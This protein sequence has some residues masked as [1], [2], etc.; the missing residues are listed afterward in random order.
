IRNGSTNFTAVN[1]SSGGGNSFFFYNFTGRSDG[2]Y[3]FFGW[4][5]DSAG[6]VVQSANRTI[7]VDTAGPVIS[8]DTTSFA[9]GT[10]NKFVTINVTS[11]DSSNDHN[12][13]SAF[14]DFNR[15]LA[16]YWRF[17]MEGA[18]ATETNA[19]DFTGYNNHG[20]LT[21]FGCTTL[22][23]NL[24]GGTG[25]TGS[26]WTSGGKRGRALAF[27][28]ENDF[29][30]VSDSSSLKLSG[31]VT[32]EGWVYPR[33]AP[34]AG[35]NYAVVGKAAAGTV[36]YLLFVNATHV[37]FNTTAQ[38]VSAAVRA[39]TV[40]A[41]SYVGASFDGL[42]VR[43]YVNGLLNATVAQTAA[44]SSTSGHL[45]VGRLGGNSAMF[46]NGSVDEV[47]VWN[48]TLSAVE[49]NASYQGGVY[50]LITNITG[51]QYPDGNYTYAAYTVDASG[52][53][54]RTEERVAVL[55][56]TLPTINSVRL[57]Y[58]NMS[59]CAY[60][61]PGS[62]TTSAATVYFNSLLGSSGVEE[63]GGQQVNIE[64]VYTDLYRNSMSGNLTFSDLPANHT[65]AD[66]TIIAYTIETGSGNATTAIYANDTA[67]NT[68]IAN[69]TFR[70]DMNDTV[71]TD[72]SSSSF[73]WVTSNVTINLTVSD[74]GATSASGANR[75][76]YCTYT[77]G[78]T[79]CIPTVEVKNNVDF[80]LP[81]NCSGGSSCTI[82]V[83]Y[84]SI[85]NV[86]NNESGG[87]NGGAIRESNT[88]NIGTG[89][90]DVQDSLVNNSAIL[91][92][93]FVR[94]SNVTNSTLNNCRVTGAVI[95]RS[96]LS[97]DLSHRFN[98][99]ISD[100]WVID[101]NITS[102]IIEKNSLVDP[103][104]VID[105]VITNSSVLNST[106]SFS[107]VENTV[108]CGN[109]TLWT[110]AVLN[111]TLVD[112]R[113][114]FNKSVYFGPM[115]LSSIC[116]GVSSSPVGSLVAEPVVVNNSA[117]MAFRYTG[118]STGYIVTIS[119]AE[120]QKLDNSSRTSI[121][122]NDNAVSP[123][124]V[125]NDAVYTANY[126]MSSLNNQSDGNKSIVAH[127]FD[128]L[129]NNWT[130]R[131]NVTLDNAVPYVAMVANSN[132]M[133][134][135]S[136]FVNLNITFSD[137][138]GV[139]DCRFANENRVFGGFEACTNS[140]VWALTGGNGVKTVVVQ[141][142]DTA[143]NVN[144]TN[145]TITLVTGGEGATIIISPQ[146]N[147][148][149]RGSKLVIV[150]A[151]DTVGWVTFNITNATNSSHTW[152]LAGTNNT[153]TNDT[154][155]DDGFSNT[156]TTT[157]AAFASESKFNLTVISYDANGNQLSN[158]TK[159]NI[160][161]DNTAPT[162]TLDIPNANGLYHG[163]VAVNASASSDTSKVRFEYRRGSGD[164]AVI[165]EAASPPFK[166]D[167]STSGL[168]DG[169]NYE[170]RANATDDAGLS[171]NVS[172]A[173]IEIDN[174]APVITIN[175]PTAGTKVSGTINVTFTVLGTVHTP[176]IQFDGG[177]WASA[178]DKT[179]HL[180]D[181]TAYADIAHAIRVRIND[182]VNNTGYSDIRVV[183]VDN[184][185]ANVILLEPVSGGYKS[186]NVDI[187]VSGPGTTF[188]VTF[189]ISNSTGYFNTTGTVN[190]L[191]LDNTS[192]DGWGAVWD[193]RKFADDSTYTV[194]VRAYS[195]SNAL[196]GTDSAINIEVDNLI[197]VNITTV[198]VYDRPTDTDGALTI[199]WT[200]TTSPDVDHYN[201]YR[202]LTQ[203]FNISTGTLLK[204]V[205]GNT[206]TDNVPAGTW[207]Y[208]V[209][210]VD[211]VGRESNAS[212]EVNTTVD[213]VGP[214]GSLDINATYARDNGTVKFTYTG[215][216][217]GFTAIVNASEMQKLDA[218][219]LHD[220][221]S[222][223]AT[224]NNNS[225]NMT[226]NST[227]T[228]AGSFSNQLRT[229]ESGALGQNITVDLSAAGV[230]N[231]SRY[232]RLL[233]WVQANTTGT[234]LNLSFGEDNYTEFVN[235]TFTINVGAANVWEQKV[236]DVSSI[237]LLNRTAIRYLMF[238]VT[239][240]T[241]FR[242]VLDDL[243]AGNQISLVDDGTRGDDVA[244]DAKY[245]GVYNITPENNVTDG[246]KTI[247]AS[248]DDG[249]GN[250][251]APQDSVTLDNTPPN[252]TVLVNEGDT[253]TI[254]MTVTL[255][256]TYLDA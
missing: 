106:V 30:N 164:W 43:I 128:T 251:L 53:M 188:N 123:D 15:G 14:V 232:N 59:G 237:P 183:T 84:Y 132:D 89:G 176:Q 254:T 41:W 248:V 231:L 235:A 81:L 194:S 48:R 187:T 198:N 223:W 155:A 133:N 63:C 213:I 138:I 103:S 86:S 135:T 215:S 26:G 193:T 90:V 100:S 242:L 225:L 109:F 256:H 149:I 145:D 23:C 120:L 172:N 238:N 97:R 233:L 88:V 161:V 5:N 212:P 221:E 72:N 217:T 136:A 32:L 143:G 202:S 38:G 3:T 99:S 87:A 82:R 11:N 222:L 243:G 140:K 158:D 115:N 35:N 96:T 211:N 83:R 104:T 57:L 160:E 228:K 220:F 121:T 208:K 134:T 24:T 40:G 33:L 216:A 13:L 154:T 71:T 226:L 119:T 125:A 234:L 214:T 167:W 250:F 139:R 252:G 173:N 60:M 51:S 159:G 144:E 17:E 141:A 52:N 80:R 177:A 178:D 22:N 44:L 197:P 229:N 61:Q 191:S 45:A 124:V 209:T 249:A 6:N 70:L 171:A 195:A 247:R 205:S 94:S 36:D 39:V 190:V 91:N 255:N 127:F 196:L 2:N 7:V 8:Y 137:A 9:N 79:P 95:I 179:Y 241:P 126:S 102:S 108:F 76:L 117:T 113:L 92:G 4:L 29:V 34:A 131:T 18:N 101:S 130:V 20:N 58:T 77:A 203:G 150:S 142:R 200:S 56:N 168:S 46:F 152:N 47:K 227:T 219:V 204:S 111:N 105:S 55:D 153:L 93:S 182:S 180:W 67:N 37:G 207:Y 10:L 98:C 62:N 148:I 64:M 116:A 244:S 189:N 65:R 170:V 31:N 112:G 162:V 174:T 175:N 210:A 192:G 42:N 199:N 230:V 253:Y 50:R 122:L 186:G 118:A 68:A 74:P 165:G 16:G 206:T 114:E 12:E 27:D 185:G 25:G 236:L 240:A 147:E 21:N 85:D 129:G 218:R 28:G 166:I 151:P 110:G 69:I 75:T 246:S 66:P 107:R 239:T 78:A 54:N 1:K 19:S 245:T 169:T 201:L 49:I 156:W 163:V 184:G 157:A 146:S 224:S 181:T 73:T